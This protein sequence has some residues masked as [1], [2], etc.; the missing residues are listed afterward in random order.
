MKLGIRPVYGRVLAYSFLPLV[1]ILLGTYGGI[2][3]LSPNIVADL[4]EEFHEELEAEHLYLSVEKASQLETLLQSL[5][6]GLDFLGEKYEDV[7]EEF[8]DTERPSYY[9]DVL[10]DKLSPRPEFSE[11]Y[12]NT[13]DFSVSS[14]YINPS[15]NFT[16][17]SSQVRGAIQVTSIMDLSFITLY[18]TRDDID[19][20]RL[21]IDNNVERE[22]PFYGPKDPSYNPFN[23]TTYNTTVATNSSEIIYSAPYRDTITNRTLI[24]LSRGILVND[25]F[26]GTVSIAYQLSAVSSTMSQLTDVDNRS[27]LLRQN[28]V[29]YHSNYST[30]SQVLNETGYLNSIYDFETNTTEFNSLLEDATSE[31]TTDVID[32]GDAVYFVSVITVR[33]FVFGFVT[34]DVQ[35]EIIGTFDLV[36]LLIAPL[37]VIGFFLTLIVLLLRRY[38]ILRNVGLETL[39]KLEQSLTDKID[40]ISDLDV[41]DIGETIRD[42]IKDRGEELRD[43]TEQGLGQKID[44][45]KSQISNVDKVVAAKINEKLD[46]FENRLVRSAEG[47]FA[48]PTEFAQQAK[49]KLNLPVDRIINLVTDPASFVARQG[50]AFDLDLTNTEEI[51]KLPNKTSRLA[52]IL[53]NQNSMAK[54]DFISLTQVPEN[55]LDP[56]LNI[57][58]EETGITSD[59]ESISFDK[60]KISPNM[61][62][63]LSIFYQISPETGMEG[64]SGPGLNPDHHESE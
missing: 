47:N 61:V 20:I 2:Y 17:L 54:T 10:Q 5:E 60:D 6:Q 46:S 33:S 32:Y 19:W 26:R 22:Y 42:E 48:N 9:H 1:L 50:E 4:S 58:P 52:S 49:D 38:G 35:P 15:L 25:V 30:T 41:E 40:K 12:N 39:M 55:E 59:T 13:V 29:V 27:F 14:Y 51:L 18:E 64:I 34:E 7:L 28:E 8:T 53:M 21:T 16:D 37:L 24:T 36:T 45:V 44:E 31:L 62:K 43:Q 63:V 3:F 57:M 56:I 23:T 11:K